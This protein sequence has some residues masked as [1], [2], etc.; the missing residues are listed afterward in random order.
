MDSQPLKQM[1]PF[2]YLVGTVPSPG[3]IDTKI[4]KRCNKADQVIGQVTPC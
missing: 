2:R 1:K 3:K 4:E